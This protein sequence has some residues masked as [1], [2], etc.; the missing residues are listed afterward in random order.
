MKNKL[1]KLTTLLAVMAI[2]GCSSTPS[3]S[4]ADTS[5]GEPTS[6]SAEPVIVPVT[7][8]KTGLNAL[9]ASKNY[10]ADVSYNGTLYFSIYVKENYVGFDSETNQE[11]LDFLVKNE[12]GIYPVN[13][14]NGNII[15]GEYKK[16]SEEENYLNLFDN[17][18]AKTLFDVAS[19]FVASVKED[20]NNVVI[21]NKTYKLALLDYLGVDRSFYVDLETV[22]ASYTDAFAIKMEFSG[23][24]RYDLVFKDFG[25]TSNANVEKFLARGGTAYVPDECMSAMQRL[26]KSNNYVVAVYDFDAG[27]DGDFNGLSQVFNPHYFYNTGSALGDKNATKQG[28]ISFHRTTPVTDTSS[29]YYIPGF[30]DTP[31]GI[32]AFIA[33]GVQHSF[34]PQVY[35]ENPDMEYFMHYPSLLKLLDKTQYFTEGTVKEFESKYTYKK[36]AYVL[37]DLTLIKDFATNFNL[38]NSFDF[39]TCVPYALGVEFSLNKEDKNCV[40]IFH[41]CFTYG[42]QKYDYLVP[43]YSFG[44]TNDSILDGFYDLYND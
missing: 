26:V 32:Y 2:T 27:V 9:N 13:R 44:Q 18:T 40:I 6:S 20:E 35:Y 41:Y 11:A 1:I 38:N 4:N 28:Y 31:C 29:Q 17:T 14:A 42:A 19:D 36:N 33:Q 22:T 21:S 3:S 16:K 10:T 12:E 15:S 37:K 24:N 30:P 23:N 8:V 34:A 43:L 39:K 7:N 25:T 5:S